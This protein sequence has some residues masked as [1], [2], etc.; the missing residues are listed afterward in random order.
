MADLRDSLPAVACEMAAYE[1]VWRGACG[2]TAAALGLKLSDNVPRDTVH[3]QVVC[4]IY[5][6]CY[7]G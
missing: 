3:L 6:T 1:A 4:Y 5:C 2:S 7:A